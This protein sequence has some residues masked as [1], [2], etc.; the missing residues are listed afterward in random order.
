MKAEIDRRIGEVLVETDEAAR[1]DTYAWL[2]ATL[3]EQAVYLP[4]SY[5]TSSYV[6]GPRLQEVGFGPTV[7]EIPFETFRPAS[8]A[9]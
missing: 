8:A 4:I 3:H 2:L 9:P 6:A 1:R 7:N 5:T